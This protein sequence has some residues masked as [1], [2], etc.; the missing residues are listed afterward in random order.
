LAAPLVAVTT[1]TS[2]VPETSK[3]A[4]Q[5]VADAERAMDSATNFHVRGLFKEGGTQI[6]VNLTMSPK[7][8]GGSVQLPGVTLQL[9]VGSGNVYVKA[10]QNSWVK[11]TGSRLTA[12]LVANR[13]ID[14]PVS[15]PDFSSF[16]ELTDPKTFIARLTSG[17]GEVS[18]LPMTPTW[19]GHKAIILE[20]AQGN[21]LYVADGATPY[22]LHVQE[23]GGV[24]SGYLTFSDFGRASMPV[25]PVNAI[26]FPN[27]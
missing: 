25:I 26:S 19:G 18:K 1:N 4:A 16:A 17:N 23:S 11:L 15:N 14:A 2:N 8:G 6:A 12:S 9:V 27:S 7:G 24:K 10:D 20:D 3:P 21:T 13:W 5:I 22:M